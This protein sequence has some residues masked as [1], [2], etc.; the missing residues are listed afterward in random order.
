MK[1]RKFEVTVAIPDD[2]KT[3]SVKIGNLVN[4]LR[5]NRCGFGAEDCCIEAEEVR[6]N[7]EKKNLG[8]CK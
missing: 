6:D 1:F 2:K 4:I 8:G 7:N 5:K 3:D